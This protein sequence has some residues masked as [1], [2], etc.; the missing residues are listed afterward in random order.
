MAFNNLEEFIQFLK[1]KRDLK[2]IETEVDPDLEITEI[3]DT[4][5]SQADLRSSLRM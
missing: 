1:K 2:V 5:L 3:V 4:S